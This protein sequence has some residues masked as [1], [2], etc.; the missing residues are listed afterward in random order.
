MLLFIGFCYNLLRKTFKYASFILN[1]PIT[2]TVGT[3]PI[4]RFII[5][6]EKNQNVI[7]SHIVKEMHYMPNEKSRLLHRDGGRNRLHAFSLS[8]F[9]E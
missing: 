2:F 5:L 4:E 7:H 1:N 6:K 8:S 3:T 9:T